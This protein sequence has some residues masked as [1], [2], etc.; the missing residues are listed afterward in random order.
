MF[1]LSTDW[2]DTLNLLAHELRSPASVIGGYARL[3]AQDR[4]P[5]ED[6]QR[7]LGKIGE[8]AGT[9]AAIGRQAESLAHWLTPEARGPAT[10]VALLTLLDQAIART[11]SPVR[12]AIDAALADEAAIDC[13]DADALAAAIG[14]VIDDVAASAPGE[15][16][17]AVV[18][19]GAS[20]RLA[21]G[22]EARLDDLRAATP[23]PDPDLLRDTRGLR[24]ALA[25][26]LS[27]VAAHGGLIWRIGG[28][29]RAIGISLPW[30]GPSRVETRI[31]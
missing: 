8:A 16:L 29:R 30:A 6:R 11:S 20:A 1:D 3:L 4:L 18:R 13:L 2:A 27:V 22:P 12:P 14:A 10:P 15:P 5:A 23:E 24:L 28:P 19:A 26:A 31:V 7:A 9:V 25:V 21:V 17:A